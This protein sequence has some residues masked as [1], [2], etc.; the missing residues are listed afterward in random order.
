MAR[1]ELKLVPPSRRQYVRTFP[2]SLLAK[3]IPG[4]KP[5]PFPGFVEPSLATLHPKAPRGD[6]W[7]HEIKYDG[8]RL[9]THIREGKVQLFTRRGHDWTDRFDNIA[10]AA[11]ELKTYGAIIDGEVIVPTPE[12]RSDFH[13]L[14]RDLGGG[15]SDRFVYYAFDL[16]YLDG[17]DLRDASLLDRKKVLAELLGSASG[18]IHLSG[19]TTAD[20]AAVFRNACELGIEGIVSKWKD[21]PYRSGRTENWHKATCRHRDTFVV[22]GWA[23]KQGK[24]DGVYLGRNEEGELVYAGKLERDF[25]EDDKKNL[26]ARL[27]P[28]RIKKAPIALPRSFPK[29]RW[30]RPEVLVDVEFRGKTGDGLLRHPSYQGIREDLMEAAT[31]DTHRRSGARRTAGSEQRR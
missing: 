10:L 1:R 12:G 7:V 19:H 31:S 30:V 8:Y 23:E 6:R 28:L 25:S 22:A 16:L 24:F 11:W 21:G 18:A 9:Q 26:P 17:L 20:G 14:E 2:A 13:A 3:E 15:R 4:V 29:A 27:E 5:A